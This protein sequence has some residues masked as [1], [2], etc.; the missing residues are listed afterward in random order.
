M[1]IYKE[2]TAVSGSMRLGLFVNNLMGAKYSR[3]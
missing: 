1:I 3:L 2:S